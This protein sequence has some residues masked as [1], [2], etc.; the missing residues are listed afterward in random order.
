[1]TAIANNIERGITDPI[2]SPPE[3]W[4][5]LGSDAEHVETHSSAPTVDEK[6]AGQEVVLITEGLFSGDACLRTERIDGVC[7]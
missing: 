3:A 4:A 5:V 6:E 2:L 1:M 7:R